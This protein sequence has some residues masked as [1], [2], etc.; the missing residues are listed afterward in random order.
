MD[1]DN[2]QD[3]ARYWSLAVGIFLLGAGVLGFIDNPIVSR[4]EANPIFHMMRIM[5]LF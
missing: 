4:P 2:N 1:R 3:L 5:P